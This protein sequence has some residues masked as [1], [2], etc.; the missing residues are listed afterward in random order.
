MKQPT[1]DKDTTDIRI[2]CPADLHWS[3]KLAATRQ[4]L[5]FKDALFQAMSLWMAHVSEVN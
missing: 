3:F 5:T 1:F 2:A 4:G